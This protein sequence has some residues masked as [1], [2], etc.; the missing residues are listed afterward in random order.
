MQYGVEKRSLEEILGCVLCRF[1]QY[2]CLKLRLYIGQLNTVVFIVE[3]TVVS[4]VVPVGN[5]C[6]MLLPEGG[7]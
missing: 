1:W 7:A 2:I 6:W 5:L 3:T 4:G